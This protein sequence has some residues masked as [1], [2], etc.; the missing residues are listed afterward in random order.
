[1]SPDART[2]PN[3]IKEEHMRRDMII[4]VVTWVAILIFGVMIGYAARNAQLP[5]C[6]QEDTCS[7][8]DYRDGHWFI[9]DKEITR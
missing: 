4:R 7:T 2:L 5:A 1:M 6:A 3:P 8:P 9:D